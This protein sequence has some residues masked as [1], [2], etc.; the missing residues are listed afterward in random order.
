MDPGR[1][2]S[3]V[4]RFEES[5]L[6]QNRAHIR[7]PGLAL[8]WLS[9]SRGLG[10]GAGPGLGELIASG[11]ER[12]RAQGRGLCG[13]KRREFRRIQ[14]GTS[15]R[16]ARMVI[17]LSLWSYLTSHRR[18][19]RKSSRAVVWVPLEAQSFCRPRR[20]P[21]LGAPRR[22]RSRSRLPLHGHLSPA[23]GARGDWPAP[24]SPFLL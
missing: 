6:L 20:C 3:G 23:L 12:G 24:G 2:G 8:Q 11:W 17:R 13:A 5:W 22:P 18:R 10:E 9:S 19:K 4:T 7:L 16:K 21:R 15:A 14:E 1:L